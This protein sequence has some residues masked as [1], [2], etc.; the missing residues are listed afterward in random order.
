MLGIVNKSIQAFLCKHHGSAVWREVADRLR[1]GPEGFEAML[2]YADDTTEALLAVA[3]GLTGKTREQLLEDIGA[4]VAQTE[5]LRRLLRFGGPDYLEFLFSLDDLQGRAQMAL[6][7]LELPELTLQ[8]E[9]QGRFT[10]LVRGRF[11][12]WGAVMAGLMRAMADDYGALV[13]I[14]LLEPREGAERVQVEL[15]FTTYHVAR[16]FDLAAPEMGEAS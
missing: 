1:L 8:S 15:H 2:T 14:D 3:E 11:P 4:E 7:D 12:G 10:L 5:P 6:P 9:A 16:Q 13:L